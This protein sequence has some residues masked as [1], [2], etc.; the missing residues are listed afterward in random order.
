[1]KLQT[2]QAHHSK[3]NYLYYRPIFTRAHLNRAI[4]SCER[5]KAAR[6]HII[7]D[8]APGKYYPHQYRQPPVNR[9]RGYRWE[10]S[11]SKSG[12]TETM[13]GSGQNKPEAHRVVPANDSQH[14]NAFKKRSS[15]MTN[16][17]STQRR[18]N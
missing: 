6:P 9:Q 3:A 5:S 7:M 4:K 8:A 2:C 10:N 1:M 13:C 16:H 15:R 17:V 14:V 18:V 11:Q 12:D